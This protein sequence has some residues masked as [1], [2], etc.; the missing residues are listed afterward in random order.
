MSSGG[1]RPAYAGFN[2]GLIA[3]L[4]AHGRQ[5]TSGPFVG[6]PVLI[7]TSVG[8]RSGQRRETPLVYSRDEENYVI[9]ASKGGA[10]TNPAWYHNLVANPSVRA[11]VLGRAFEVR[12]RVTQG[13]ERDR[14][15]RRHADQ[16]PNF[17]EYERKTTRQIPVIVLE[18]V[19]G[20]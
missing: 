13:E 8:A 9:V 20:A 3:D 16:N 6:R 2:E 18:P 17:Y 19:A 11:E 7:V 10:P 1:N 12:A 15:F 5:A 14:L 4:R